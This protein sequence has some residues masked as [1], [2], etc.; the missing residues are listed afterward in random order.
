MGK[1]AWCCGTNGVYYSRKLPDLEADFYS[2]EQCLQN[3]LAFNNLFA[4]SAIDVSSGFQEA[5][6]RSG[7]GH[8]RKFAREDFLLIDEILHNLEFST[9]EIFFIDK[10]LI[11]DD[12]EGVL[13]KIAPKVGETD[14]AVSV[15][16]KRLIKALLTP[17]PLLPPLTPSDGFI[18]ISHN[19]AVSF[20]M[21]KG[22]F[23][24][25][26]PHSVREDKTL[27]PHAGV[28][29]FFKCNNIC[30]L[31]NLLLQGHPRDNADFEIS[32]IRVVIIK[33]KS[34]DY[35]GIS[36]PFTS[37]VHKKFK[38]IHDTNDSVVLDLLGGLT[39]SPSFSSLTPNNKLPLPKKSVKRV[40]RPKKRGIRKTS[41]KTVEV[42]REEARKRRLDISLRSFTCIGDKSGVDLDNVNVYILK[43][44]SSLCN[45][46]T[47]R[48]IGVTHGF[49]EPPGRSSISF[50]KIQG[51]VYHL[52]F[53][54][55]YMESTNNTML[56]IKD[57]RE[58]ERL[59]SDR[60]LDEKI[61]QDIQ[62][63]LHL[64]NPLI[65]S[66]RQLN[67]EVDETTHLVFENT[68]R[69]THG[70]ILGDIPV[71]DEIAAVIK[72]GINFEPRN[73][74][75]WKKGQNKP[76]TVSI[77]DSSYETLQYPLIFPHA[78]SGWSPIL[79]DINSKKITQTKYY[80]LFLLSEPRFT[81]LQRLSQEYFVDMW[82]RVEVEKLQYIRFN[83][84]SVLR[85]GS[86]RE[87]DETVEG[88]GGVTAGRVYLPS[89]FTHGPR[90]MQVHYH[91]AIAIVNKIG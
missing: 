2:Q 81:F 19:L 34:S 53:D 3:A 50:V 8:C 46:N 80:R 87:L 49:Q 13:A 37:P 75:I 36:S 69:R 86:R 62:N 4:F 24:V 66:I 59:A 33:N 40:G 35:S 10:F 47:H 77:L 23:F 31:A 9:G 83:Q 16:E 11:T 79:T 21:D 43:S 26:D 12:E 18:F 42:I 52:V 57:N 51:R 28:A 29:R 32:R 48:S 78:S 25:F 7:S 39:V 44:L 76:R 20:W 55:D 22:I 6:G 71:A 56:Y 41:G 64:V 54:L 85:I 45:V 61:C 70:P 72:F 91:I 73:V 84:N 90:Y 67:R 60:K 88:E 65:K 68:S 14:V 1:S 38:G 17:D 27:C 63:Y 82:C 5:P 58:R 74:V 30:D 89:S 15:V